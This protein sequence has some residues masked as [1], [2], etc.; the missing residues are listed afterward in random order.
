MFAGGDSRSALR[1]ASKWFE[2]QGSIEEAI[3]HAVA[4]DDQE[5]AADIIERHRSEPL[6]T[7]RWWELR[8]WL[9]M[10]GAGVKQKRP[11]ILMSHGWLAYFRLQLD[12]LS[13]IVRQT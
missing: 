9:D 11:A 3:R 1:N 10:L 5:A 6:D 12:A 7:D 8:D 4:A 13:L 2:Q